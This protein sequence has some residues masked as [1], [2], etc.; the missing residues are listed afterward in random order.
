[1]HILC[2]VTTNVLVKLATMKKTYIIAGRF[3]QLCFSNSLRLA[4]ERRNM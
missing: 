3:V 2:I 1:L 4:P